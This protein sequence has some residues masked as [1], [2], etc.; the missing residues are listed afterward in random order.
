MP[1]ER[2]WQ[3]HLWVDDDDTRTWLVGLGVLPA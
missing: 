2:G 1:A 3:T